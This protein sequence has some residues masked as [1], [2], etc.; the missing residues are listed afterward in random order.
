MDPTTYQAKEAIRQAVNS[1]IQ[2]GVSDF[3]VMCGWNAR[4]TL[5]KAN[6]KHWHMVAE[7]HDSWIIDVRN[8]ERL[9][10]ARTFRDAFKNPDLRMFGIHLAVPMDVE[11]KI[12]P[13]WK[14]LEVYEEDLE[15]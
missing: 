1:P 15:A 2:G 14:E 5:K 13:N 11:I 9:Q 3:T 12:G 7:Q 4:T 10:V 8:E 6:V